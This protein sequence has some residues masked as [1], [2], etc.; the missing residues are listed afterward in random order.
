MAA[1]GIFNQPTTA[2]LN[3]L[4]LEA[5]RILIRNA[6]A[7]G[8]LQQQQIQGGQMSLDQER[9]AVADQQAARAAQINYY[10]GAPPANALAPPGG[11][12]QSGP[13]DPSAAPPGAG[14]APAPPQRVARPPVPTIGELIR[15]GMPPAAATGF[16]ESLQKIEKTSAEIDASH[17]T[18]AK[19]TADAQGAIASQRSDMANMLVQTGMNPEVLAWNLDHYASLGPQQA[20]EAQQLKQRLGS[21]APGDQLALMKSMASAPATLNA[22]TAAS[23]AANTA[24]RFEAEAPGI[25]S[26][27]LTAAQQAAGTAPIQPTDK[28]RL[29][30]EAA[31]AAETRRH[32]R[33]DESNA[34]AARESLALTPEARDQMADLF[35]S[36]G[37]LPN[38]GMGAAV[39]KTRSDIINRTAAKYPSGDMALNA[40][41]YKANTSSLRNVQGTL[42]TLTAFE[43]AGLKNLKMFTD[44]AAKIPDTGIPWLNLPVRMLDEKLVGSTN[45]TVVNAAR[46]IGLREIARVTNDPKL[47]GVLSDSARHEVQGFAP[48]NAT[49]PQIMAVV[50]TLQKDMANV[51]SSLTEQRDAIQTR[52]KNPMGGGDAST[53]GSAAKIPAGAVSVTDPAGGVHTFPDAAAADQFRK[54][55]NIK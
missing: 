28:A 37:Q 27:N 52:I 49:L 20:A 13:P 46:E 7:A 26:R 5:K 15:R 11:S 34:A 48:A 16:L 10:S 6:L 19:A 50:K 54:L 22:N 14:P 21:L 3:P 41:E 33:V 51:H 32:N 36:T 17:A 44:A 4:D 40:A 42:D 55:A 25:A 1:F 8:T 31:V 47:S 29:E 18:A 35:H 24:A 53:G 12:P 38:L 45:M 30:R 23:T 2:I 43:S 39:A 9:R